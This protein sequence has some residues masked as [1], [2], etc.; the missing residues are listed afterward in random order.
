MGIFYDSGSGDPMVLD[1][2]A[3]LHGLA[4][5]LRKLATDARLDE[6][7]TAETNGSPEPYA[8]FLPGLRVQKVMRD[9]PE[10]HLAKDRWL[11][12][13]ASQADLEKL[14]QNLERLQNGEHTHL[15]SSPI[16]L[17]FEADDS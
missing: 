2:K 10:C 12:L 6:V 7:F 5:E 4:R 8:E 15:Y 17:V 11:E 14:C 1:R 3:A 9:Y 16:S 13:R